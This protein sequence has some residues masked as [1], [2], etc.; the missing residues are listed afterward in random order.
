MMRDCGHK[1]DGY[2]RTLDGKAHCYSCIAIF[3]Q[4]SMDNDGHSKRLPLYLSGNEVTNWPGSLR[5]RVVEQSSGR[6]NIAGT[7]ED[8]WFHDRHGHTW[9]GV[10]YGQWTQ[11]VHCKRLKTA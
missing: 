10:Q 5:F 3:D 7:R 11:I 2:G 9:H 1:A 8:V 6:H 4:E